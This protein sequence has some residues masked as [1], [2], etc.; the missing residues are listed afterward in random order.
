MSKVIGVF[1]EDKVEKLL[2]QGMLDKDAR[3]RLASFLEQVDVAIFSANREIMHKAVPALSRESFIRFAVVVAEARA[4]Y[5]KLALDLSKKGHPS[6]ADVQRL[7]IAR[8][9]F[10]ELTH[11]FEATHR[12][13]KRG[14]SDIIS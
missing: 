13:I 8:E 4:A 5:I 10:D 7:K 2:D 1:N 14:Y 6:D 11:A 3:R 12:L 9:A